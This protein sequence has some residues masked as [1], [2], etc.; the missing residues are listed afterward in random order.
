MSSAGPLSPLSS[1]PGTRS[2]VVARSD[3]G[4]DSVDELGADSVRGDVLDVDSLERGLRGRRRRRQPRHQRPRRAQRAACRGLAAPRPAAHVRGGQ[5]RRGGPPLRRTT[6]GAGERRASSTPTRA[7]TGSP[8][9][10]RWRSPTMNEP[11]AVGESH[12]Q[13]YTCDSRTAVVLR[14]GTIVGDDPQTRYWLRAAERGRAH[15]HRPPLRLGARHPHRR[16][17]R[18]RCSPRCTRRA[19]STTWAPSRCSATTSCRGTPTRPASSPAPFLGVVG[20]WLIG[21]AA[22]AAGPVAA[23]VLPTTSPPRPA[24]V[25][26]DPSSTPSWLDAAREGSRSPGR[27]VTP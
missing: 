18:R 7:T 21:P 13:D 24:G 3:A 23:G 1:R 16:P 17:R 26:A 12:V 10:A 2:C 9:T 20:R 19:G 15:R 14:F 22:R 25:R 4:A 6:G 27:L 8:S 5:R 11:T